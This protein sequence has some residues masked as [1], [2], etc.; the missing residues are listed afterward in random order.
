MI[1]LESRDGVALKDEEY[2]ITDEED[3]ESDRSDELEADDETMLEDAED[4]TSD[5]M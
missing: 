5:E 4:D 3:G 2:A 1:E